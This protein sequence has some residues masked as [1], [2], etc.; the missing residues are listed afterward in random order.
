VGVG[1]TV[2]V[3]LGIKYIYRVY[4]YI[5][6]CM[7]VCVLDQLYTDIGRREISFS[8]FVYS[9]IISLFLIVYW[10]STFAENTI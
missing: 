5:Y 10:D 1:I 9:L 3:G 7:C 6:I 4:I 2:R 8:V